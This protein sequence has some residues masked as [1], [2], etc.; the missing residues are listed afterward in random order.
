[1]DP[2]VPHLETETRV[3]AKLSVRHAVQDGAVIS[4]RKKVG[5]LIQE[6][7]LAKWVDQN[8]EG[9]PEDGRW[10]MIEVA[11]SAGGIIRKC[12]AG[13]LAARTG[14][15]GRT[16]EERYQWR[17]GHGALW[18]L[19]G[20]FPEIETYRVSVP[21]RTDWPRGGR[22]VL[23]LDPTLS[24]REVLRLYQA[25][26][27]DLTA[28]DKVRPIGQ[29]NLAVLE[30]ALDHPGMSVRELWRDWNR[31][32]GHV[33]DYGHARNMDRD[34]KATAARLTRGALRGF[35]DLLRNPK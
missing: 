34:I 26:R 23:T 13:S 29:E 2:L 4:L 25:A 31:T 35:W 33:K 5:R 21:S 28:Q 11:T 22:I 9:Q 19:T 24:P 6:S 7:E 32:M 16:L 1:M 30:F 18:L 14:K 3:L 10:P 20:L 12:G 8:R 27:K 15:L 17:P